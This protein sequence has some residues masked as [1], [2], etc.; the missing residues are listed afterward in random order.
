M[1]IQP[2]AD[3]YDRVINRISREEKLMIL[4]KKLILESFGLVISFF[5]FIPLTLKLLSDIA[6]SGLTQFLSLLFTDFSIVMSDIGNYVLSLLESTPAL[7]LSLVLAALL[8][9]IFSLA[10]LTDSY[11]DFKKIIIN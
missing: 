3:L 9:T 1:L 2:R 4:K 8:A 7:S 10:K 11:S 6:K 5:V